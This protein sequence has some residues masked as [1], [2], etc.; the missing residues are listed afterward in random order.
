MALFN[1]TIKNDYF[2]EKMKET[3]L[4]HIYKKGS[5]TE[6]SNWRGIML[7]NFLAN[8]PLSWLNINLTPY[9][10]KKGMIPDT[11]VACQEGIQQRDVISYLSNIK[12]WAERNKKTVYMLKRD[13]MKGFDFLSPQGFY[14]AIT[15]YGLPSQIITLNKAALENNRCHPKTAFG[16]AASFVT[17]GLTRQG[18]SISP[19][20]CVLTSGMLHRW[21]SDETMNLP[22]RL[23]I[24]T[25][26]A[27]ST[28]WHT[29]LDD[30]RVRP[31]MVEAMDDS[32]VMGET[33]PFMT[34]STAL[35]ETG[36]FTYG[37][38]TKFAKTHCYVVGW[39][40][41]PEI[42]THIEFE[43]ISPDDPTDPFRL[44]TH[45][46]P[47][48]KNNAEFLN[49]QM[50]DPGARRETIEEVIANFTYPSLHRRLPITIIRKVTNQMLV[51]KIRPLLALQP[52]TDE[53]AIDLDHKV[54][55]RIH[56]MLGFPYQANS[57]LLYLPVEKGGFGFPCLR[58]I[59]ATCTIEGI[60]RDLNHSIRVFR[61]MALI[62]LGD[63][64]CSI[65]NCTCPITGDPTLKRT[66]SRTPIP[67]AWRTA[68]KLLP[69]MD[70]SILQTNQSHWFTGDV[71]I[72]HYLRR[73]KALHPGT[74]IEA[75][76]TISWM[77][78][79]KGIT[80]TNQMSKW[81]LTTGGIETF[82]NE[83]TS[84][85]VTLSAQ[86][87]AGVTKFVNMINDI[88][89]R[90]MT[91]G[92][93]QLIIE[94]ETRREWRKQWVK[95]MSILHENKTNTV[96]NSEE[97]MIVWAT[98]GSMKSAASSLGEKR[99]VT[100]AIIGPKTLTT[101]DEDQSQWVIHGEVR[102]IAMA[103]EMISADPMRPRTVIYTDHLNAKRTLDDL[104]SS[105]EDYNEKL[106]NKPARSLYKWAW[107]NLKDLPNVELR[108]TPGHQE[109]E[110]LPARA[111][112]MADRMAEEAHASKEACPAIIPTEE[113]DEYTVHSPRLGWIESNI[114]E[115]IEY[116]L[117][118]RAQ[119]ELEKKPRL[120]TWMY[121][122]RNHPTYPYT[123]AVS[124]Y[125]AA[126]QLYARSGQLPVRD[127]V[128]E[129][130]KK[131]DPFCIYGCTERETV[132]H[133]MAECPKFQR[134]RQEAAEKLKQKT[135]KIETGDEWPESLGTKYSQAAEE[136]FEDSPIWPR[137]E[138]QYYLGHVPRITRTNEGHNSRKIIKG[139]KTMH[140]EFHYSG[141]RLASR[142]FGSRSRHLAILASR[143]KP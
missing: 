104:K 135:K 53:D 25:K 109:T 110:S 21:V 71:S 58:K 36:Q 126:V 23:D 6:L 56:K 117:N 69:M 84:I 89:L 96:E 10:R 67:A 81:T 101:R 68:A 129:R 65:N 51:T 119:R 103:L 121:D 79:R 95:A 118:C 2:P 48:E 80:R 120:A 92:P 82:E 123:R 62:T 85:T 76:G 50:D 59:N 78:K 88:G 22:G 27:L 127:V 13:Q 42:P 130:S 17:S 141:I 73:A 70:L 111:N 7:T 30:T 136:Y 41:N 100:S 39:I 9:M 106:R 49:A 45:M 133:V 94:P 46:I 55:K 134:W 19:M 122:Q 108:Y 64:M 105:P 137:K 139:V 28:E 38:V 99:V 86:A 20:K 102:A 90:K 128:S 60:R 12:S 112:K 3:T 124:A 24:R 98:D 113:M 87:E 44:S 18:G 47:V 29:P 1:Y 26:L 63:W 52:V 116:E 125:S 91:N 43:S 138:T 115:V 33:I 14:D 74:A 37:S 143:E 35:L 83:K 93:A 16:L 61:D 66:S 140:D 131:I 54:A 15:A 97:G 57:L 132:H 75:G 8:A 11:Q 5:R 77:L 31:F 4:L 34:K 107:K 32:I 114:Q 72:T 40:S 142:I